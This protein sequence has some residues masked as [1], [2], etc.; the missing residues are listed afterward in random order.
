MF[1][2]YMDNLQV[3][4]RPRIYVFNLGD[5]L[6]LLTNPDEN[7][8]PLMKNLDKIACVCVV[9]NLFHFI[10]YYYPKSEFG[11]ISYK[12]LSCAQICYQ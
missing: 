7:T 11:N 8:Q 2:N 1:C 3:K 12:V 6:G 9:K 10:M 5:I 4:S